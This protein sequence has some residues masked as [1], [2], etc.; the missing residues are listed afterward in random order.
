MIERA[1]SC[2]GC[3]FR[4]KRVE[5]NQVVKKKKDSTFLNLSLL[6]PMLTWGGGGFEQLNSLL[7]F[8]LWLMLRL[9]V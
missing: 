8:F 6:G 3:V 4:R 9:K 7:A 5:T 2:E 1:A